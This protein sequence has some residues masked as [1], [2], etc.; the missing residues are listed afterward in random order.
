MTVW[1][2]ADGCPR[3]IRRVVIRAALRTGCPAVF[4]ADRLLPLE[5][6]P[7]LKLQI[8]EKGRDAADRYLQKAA[9]PGDL[10]VT[11][12]IPLAASLVEAGVDVVHPRGDLLSPETIAER[13][14]MRDFLQDLRDKGV[15]TSTGGTGNRR[16]RHGGTQRFAA[17][18][19]RELTRRLAD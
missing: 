18:L 7:L 3:P 5:D 11:A 14:S 12:D 17:T 15:D 1:V 2:D 6:S 19:D 10:A 9:A 8:V 4:V 16:Y 13:L